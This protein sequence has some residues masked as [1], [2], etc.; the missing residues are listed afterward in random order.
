LIACDKEETFDFM[1]AFGQSTPH[2][3][4]GGVGRKLNDATNRCPYF[5]EKIF[6]VQ[7]GRVQCKN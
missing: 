5:S 1:V 3:L 4:G 7:D 2:L 6:V